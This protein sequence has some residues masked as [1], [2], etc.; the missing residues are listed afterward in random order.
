VYAQ[1]TLLVIVCATYAC[2]APLILAAGLCYFGLASYIYKHQMLYVYEPAFETGGKWWPKMARCIVLAL[3]F[4]QCTMVGMMILKETYTEI[5]FLGLI[6]VSTTIYSYYVASK[7][8]P[9]AAQLPFDM[10]MAMDLDQ[11]HSEDDLAGVEGYIQPSLRA[12]Y[13]I[14]EVDFVVS[15]QEEV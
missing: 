1:D 4:A 2:I 3:L 7:Y 6:I 12:H 14:P 11:Q 10:A 5:Y 15:K 13:L 8:E 9:I